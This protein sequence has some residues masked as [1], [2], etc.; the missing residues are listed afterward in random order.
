MKDIDKGARLFHEELKN[1]VKQMDRLVE[2]VKIMDE[3]MEDMSKE[4]KFI[5]REL[6]IL[7]RGKLIHY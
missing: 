4:F 3:Q 1:T 2:H 6:N 7:S 5:Y